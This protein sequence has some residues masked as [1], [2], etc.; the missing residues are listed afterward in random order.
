MKRLLSGI[1]SALMLITVLCS[2]LSA[3]VIALELGTPEI[4]TGTCEIEFKP[5]PLYANA[6]VQGHIEVTPVEIPTLDSFNAADYSSVANGGLSL[7]EQMKQRDSS[8]TVMVFSDQDSDTVVSQ[9]FEIALEH[10]GDPTEG[11]YLAW[12]YGGYGGSVS[13]YTVNGAYYYEFTLNIPYYTTAAQ[14][15][16]MDQ[17]VPELLDELDLD[18]KNDYLKTKGVYDWLCQ[19][20]TY[21]YDNLEDDTYKLKHAAYAALVDKTAV[22]QGYAVLFYRLMLELGVDNRVITGIGN[23]GP[24]AWN[25]VELNDLYYNLDAT[26]DAGMYGYS[27]F[28]TSDANFGDHQRD[29]EYTTSAFYAEYPMGTTNYQPDDFVIS[30]G[31]L[32]QYNGNDSVVVIPDGVTEIGYGAFYEKNVTKVILPE[33]LRTIGNEAFAYCF[34]LSEIII[35]ESVTSIGDLAFFFCLD[36]ETVIIYSDTLA[37]N[38]SSLVFP[39]NAI[40]YGNEGSTAQ[41][42]ATKYSRTF[43]PLSNGH[44]YGDWQDYNDDKHI[45]YC[46][47][48]SLN[49]TQN[50]IYTDAQDETCNTCGHERKIAIDGAPVDPDDMMA[51]GICGNL[52]WVLSNEGVLHILGDG[53]MTYPLGWVDYKESIKK[54]IVYDGVTSIHQ[55]AFEGCINLTGISIP[56]S[57]TEIEHSAF[58]NCSSLVS[59]DIPNSVESIGAY[60]FKNCTSLETVKLP[61]SIITIGCEMFAYCSNLT[62]ISIPQSVIMIDMGVFRNCTSLEKVE[63][64]EGLI[65]ICDNAFLSCT[66][67]TEIVLPES[68]SCIDSRAFDM[69]SVNKLT[70]LSMDV[71]FGNAI[72]PNTAVIWCHEGSTAEVYAINNSMT[73]KYLSPL[74]GDLDGDGAVDR[75]DALFLLYHAIFGEEMY[76]ANQKADFNGDGAVDGFDALHLLY[77]SV[78][79][80]SYSLL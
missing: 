58:L 23:G 2:G 50:H 28:L 13:Y 12:Q 57:V 72:V 39:Q 62:E 30:N 80:Q 42:Y 65:R 21:D 63:F 10:T 37:I 75:K 24:H 36:L 15:A 41:A 19:N 9:L 16:I 44:A 34:D 76:P 78:F 17:K 73:Y 29:T 20:V 74:K 51:S 8:V 31:V 54:V 25:I 47:S 5:N 61:N 22:C 49:E 77:H 3:Q 11:D 6:P 55:R 48:C 14:E 38:D 66:S 69:T 7:R 70:V 79:S 26:W 64:S 56:S 45:R 67:L 46:I 33:G 53:Q 59:I 40:I 68:L 4:E 71:I 43:K 18:G 60:T 52:R 35:P 27:Y 1:L 32:V